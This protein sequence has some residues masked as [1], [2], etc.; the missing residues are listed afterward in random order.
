MSKSRMQGSARLWLATAAGVLAAAT[1]FAVMMLRNAPEP[2]QTFRPAA[3]SPT[4]SGAI[5][6]AASSPMAEERQ[7]TN[8]STAK[9]TSS[10]A[11]TTRFRASEDYLQFVKDALPAAINNDG[12]AAWYIAEALGKCAFVMRSYRNSADPEAQLMQQLAGMPKAPQWARDNVAHS[13]HRCLGLAQDDPVRDLPARDGGYPLKYWE[14]QAL[15]NGDALAQAQAAATA[16]SLV[17]LTQNMSQDEKAAQYKIAETDL[18]SAVVSGDPDALY[19]AGMLLADPR[20]SSDTLNGVAVALAAC[21]LGRDCSA[22]NPEN[23][24]SACRVSGA[25]PADADFAYFLQQSL[26]PDDYA[27]V[28]AHAQQVKQSVQAGDWDA[29]MA[30]L[31]IDKAALTAHVRS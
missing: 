28:Y 19:L 25:C 24:F 1:L 12:R 10:T 13:T 31:T 5:P 18:R 11:W 15:E 17:A 9:S 2:A 20:Y 4:T 29:V 6:G 22:N 30:V 14:Q 26:G 16:L 7:G 23:S 21:D 27:K 8:Q 3:T